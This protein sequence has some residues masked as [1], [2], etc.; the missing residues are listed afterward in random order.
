MIKRKPSPYCVADYRSKDTFPFF[1]NY[2]HIANLQYALHR[3]QVTD[4]KA[5]HD[6][7][8]ST[9][10]LGERII[11]SCFDEI[12]GKAKEIHRKTIQHAIPYYTKK[13]LSSIR[14]LIS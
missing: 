9:E 13:N 10:H 12:E 5:I 2:H 1:P 14:N 11:F 8:I 7:I 6:E 4:P 3:S